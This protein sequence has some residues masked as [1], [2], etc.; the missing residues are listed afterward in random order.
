MKKFES[1]KLTCVN[2]RSIP[3]K[4]MSKLKGG[5]FCINYDCQCHGTTFTQATTDAV[6]EDDSHRWN[7]RKECF[8]R[9]SDNY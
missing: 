1:L 4:D 9:W 7:S 3:E 6:L 5:S 8:D 2:S